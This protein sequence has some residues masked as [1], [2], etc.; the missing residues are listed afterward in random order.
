MPSPSTA[1]ATTR[2]AVR[3]R[4]KNEDDQ[5]E[6]ISPDYTYDEPEKEDDDENTYD[7]PISSRRRTAPAD[8]MP[9]PDP[10]PA[11]VCATGTDCTDCGSRDAAGDPQCRRRGA[12]LGGVEHWC[13]DSM[14]GDGRCDLQCNNRECGH[15]SNDCS[16]DEILDLCFPLHANAKGWRSKPANVSSTYRATGTNRSHALVAMEAQLADLKPFDVSLDTDTNKWWLG[17][18]FTLHLRWRDARY[19]VAPCKYVL[20]EVLSLISTQADVQR[21]TDLENSMRQMIWMP[22]LFLEGSTLNGLVTESDQSELSTRYGIKETDFSFAP[23]GNWT[24][25]QSPPDGAP[26]CLDCLTYDLRINRNFQIVAPTFEYFPFDS[27][28][29]SFEIAISDTDLFACSSLL[30]GLNLADSGVLSD[31]IGNEWIAEN[32][33]AKHP[34]GRSRGTVDRSACVVELTVRRNLMI[35]VIKQVIPTIM[36][37]Y[38]S[39]MAL[40]MSA[41]QHTGDRAGMILVGALILIVNFQSDIGLGNITYLVWWASQH[42][43]RTFLGSSLTLAVECSQVGLLQPGEHD[44]ASLGAHRSHL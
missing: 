23:E 10:L 13:L 24:T 43:P 29:F 9:S 1:C 4:S 14:L 21:R 5:A 11:D 42:L 22:R 25:D 18:A 41:D 15:D 40:F 30:D 26:T 38:C 17:V 7:A 34:E 8:P 27:Q 44:D 20:P 39:L 28:V 12:R 35:F 6:V 36:V 37:V 31:L 2:R 33:E 32:I 16:T 19:N 3:E